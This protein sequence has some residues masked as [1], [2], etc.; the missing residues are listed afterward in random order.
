MSVQKQ[1]KKVSYRK[2]IARGR[3]Y[4][5]VCLTPSLITMQNLVV[6]SHTVWA[7]DGG[8]KNSEDAWA[9]VFGTGAWPTL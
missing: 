2:Q 8:P 6:V 4:A 9:P 7:Y 1:N 3:P 5:K